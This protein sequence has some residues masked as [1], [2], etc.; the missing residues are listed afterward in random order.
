MTPSRTWH[1]WIALLLWFLADLLRRPQPYFRAD[2]GG[3]VYLLRSGD[4]YKIGRTRQDVHKRVASLRTGN[5]HTLTLIHHFPARDMYAAERKLH[6][7]F[8]HKRLLGE[9]N[10]TEWFRL[11][12][13]DIRH[14]KS[15]KRM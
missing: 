15:I 10:G 12:S 5:P 6:D 3:T 13:R 11:N 14:I 9:E 8:Q 4:Y 2:N 1:D 7:L